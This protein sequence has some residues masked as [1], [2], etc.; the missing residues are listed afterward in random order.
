MSVQLKLNLITEIHDKLQRLHKGLPEKNS[1]VARQLEQYANCLQFASTK[2]E[3]ESC[4]KIFGRFCTESLD[5]DTSEYKEY[6]K[7]SEE[8]YKIA[9]SFG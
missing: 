7:L 5:W 6:I 1:C 2:H 8:G 9:K 4:A 3:I